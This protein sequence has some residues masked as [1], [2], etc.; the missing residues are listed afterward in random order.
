[1]D[2]ISINL[3]VAEGLLAPYQMQI[4]SCISGEEAI[5]LTEKNHYNLILMDHLMPCMNGIETVVK[6][7][8]MEEKRQEKSN[9]IP[10]VALTADAIVGMKEMFLENGFDDYL[11]KPIEISTMNVIIKKWVPKEKQVSVGC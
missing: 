8:A 5:S 10:I 9:R 4:D 3:L 7:R 1:V 2:D 11:S 6:I